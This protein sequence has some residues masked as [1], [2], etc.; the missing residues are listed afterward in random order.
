[1]TFGRAMATAKRK[2]TKNIFKNTKSLLYHITNAFMVDLATQT[3]CLVEISSH[4]PAWP[5]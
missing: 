2:S 3:P 4:S 1:M 5:F